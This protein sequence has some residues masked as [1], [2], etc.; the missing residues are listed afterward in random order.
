MDR[1]NRIPKDV[2]QNSIVPLPDIKLG[3][4]DTP[5]DSTE[6]TNYQ[7]AAVDESLATGP[8]SPK[9]FSPG[10]DLDD[11][12]NVVD[13][14]PTKTSKNAQRNNRNTEKVIT[15]NEIHSYITSSERKL[16]HNQTV[17]EL[18]ED[19]NAQQFSVIKPSLND[20]G[21]SSTSVSK[22]SHPDLDAIQTVADL[23]SVKTLSNTGKDNENKS[24]VVKYSTKIQSQHAKEIEELG[25]RIEGYESNKLQYLITQNFG[26]NDLPDVESDESQ[27]DILA[28]RSL[29]EQFGLF[30]DVLGIRDVDVMV[31]DPPSI[32]PHLLVKS[33]Y[34]KRIQPFTDKKGNRKDDAVPSEPH[35]ANV[36]KVAIITIKLQTEIKGIF[37]YY[38][39][40]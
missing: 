18:A 13:L 30:D 10:S 35:K 24:D 33:F 29:A 17:A 2:D 6:G 34:Q 20:S 40:I 8:G 5:A 9:S 3:D 16:Y 26:L 14:F 38:I 25:Q 11:I 31:D 15:E 32:K 21:S 23:S 4:D 37:Y 12:Q 39:R 28:K 27:R 1:G 19:I 22:S 36:C 7:R